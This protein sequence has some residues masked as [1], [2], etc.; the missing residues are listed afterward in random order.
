MSPFDEQQGQGYN[1]PMHR[2][3]RT[4]ALAFMVLCLLVAAALRLPDLPSLPPGVHYDEAANGVLAGDIGLRGERPVFIPSYTGKEPLFFYLA[5]G[6]M[7]TVGESLF[8]LRLTAAY[9]G[10]LTVAATYWLGREMLADRRIALLAA[11]LLAVSFWHVL[12][13]R[14]GFRA[15]SEPLLQALT[16]AALFRGLRGGRWA[17]FGV[18]GVLLG[19]T[20]YTYLAS[21]LFPV[22]L[23]LGA[24][25]LL[26]DR[27][28]A[29]QRWPQLALM[30]GVAFLVIS[31]L[32]LYFA[33]NPDAFWTRIGQ[34]GPNSGGLTLLES[35]G[36]SLGMF[37]LRGDPYLRFNLP[38]RPLFNV[39]WG[40]LLVVGWVIALLRVRRMPYDWQRSALLLLVAAPF[41]MLLP[42][43]L[44]TN[45]IVPSNLRVIGLIPFVFYLP[46]IGLIALLRDLERR[47]DLPSLVY[48]IQ[49]VVVLT[50]LAGGAYAAW[51]YFD[52]WGT[53]RELVLIT[54]GDL[55]AAA[56]VI[57]DLLDQEPE[58]TQLYV[59][60]PHYR[61]PT[62]AFLSEQYSALKWLPQSQALVLPPDGE[63][64][65]LYP[66][67]SPMPEWV[68]SYLSPVALDGADAGGLFEL[69]A[70][71]A[72]AAVPE[73]IVDATFANA[74][75]LLGYD[76]APGAAGTTLPLTLYWRIDSRLPPD[77]PQTPATFVHLEDAA[78]YRWSQLETDAYPAEQ[79]TPGETIIQ[80]V[81]LPLPD[82]QPPGDYRLR[83]GLFEPGTGVRLPRLD[84]ANRFAGDS[85]VLEPAPVLPG[86]P[87][88]PLPEPPRLL[89]DAVVDGL[90]L[91]GYE[92]P[93]R[94]AATGEPGGVA[95]WW[96]ADAP[97][98]ALSL[99][100][101]AVDTSGQ[102]TTLVAGQPAY[103]SYPF[104]DWDTPAFVIDRQTFTWPDD[105]PPG[106]YRYELSV[107]D[108]SGQVIFTADL[109][110]VALSATERLFERP[111][112]ATE[113]AA[114]FGDIIALAGYT[115]S[116]DGPARDLELVWQALD[117]PTADYTVFV[118]VLNP[119]GTCCAW[120]QD[121]MP[122]GGAYP[123][124][125]WRPGE[126]VVDRYTITLPDDLPP[127][128]YPLQVGL[129][130]AETGV[131]LA[132]EL[133]GAANQDA[134]ILTTFQV[135]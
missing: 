126:Y 61:H 130:L 134:L 107:L 53:Q 2:L 110:P 33:G 12:F 87:P 24:L 65:V 132:V 119:D 82:G 16:V 83:V 46:A 23:L 55:T 104:A 73:Q 10:I 4:R 62:L 116:G 133:S 84:E 102:A 72:T 77:G 103:D 120:Q 69:Y 124:S 48:G 38:E 64:M 51:L 68:R 8:S 98:P 11:A 13:S 121:T 26:L 129:Y 94:T 101:A 76:I 106:D 93:A 125:R 17:W 112:L 60:S 96:A 45:E 27:D 19:L 41:I 1:P 109:G 39:L 54:D 56:P 29:R 105:R 108:E 44:A 89:N 49:L 118:Q 90:T 25:P 59:A 117:A 71:T 80:R 36:R 122:Q 35:V 57:D 95:L 115:L 7:R 3:T 100:L 67:N 92:S 32:L 52:Q 34:V 86:V 58:G 40:G 43:A 42:A 111:P 50:L 47:F 22:L 9:I 5:G 123:T 99:R 28:T 20:G 15:I 113:T 18:A 91:L 30:A 75:T 88:E 128:E 70:I 63:G 74:I 31:P 135:E 114:T 81:D 78:G 21:R 85:V 14:L 37:F 97:L 6:L 79:W 127:G 131:R 66:A